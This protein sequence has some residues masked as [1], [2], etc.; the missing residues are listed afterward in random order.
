MTPSTP[1]VAVCQ[2]CWAGDGREV[3]G[4]VPLCGLG[5]QVPTR[6]VDCFD[7]CEGDS[8]TV[9]RPSAEG[10]RAGGRPCWLRD[11]HD[12]D[13][14]DAVSSWLE[15]GG[16]GVAEIPDLLAIHAFTPPRRVR[17]EHEG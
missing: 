4:R 14:L 10:R 13:V 6:G 17:V 8:V 2:E 3:V 12:P 1:N 16:P 11:V 15:A 9:V 7:V 5:G